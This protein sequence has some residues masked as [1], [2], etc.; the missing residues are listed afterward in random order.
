MTDTDNLHIPEFAHGYLLAVANNIFTMTIGAFEDDWKSVRDVPMYAGE[1]TEYAD[2]DL[3]FWYD[4]DDDR[5]HCTAYHIEYDSVKN[6]E[7]TNTG[8]HRRLW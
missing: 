3:N 8:E 2:Y 1:H 6:T 7:S 4:K 5:W